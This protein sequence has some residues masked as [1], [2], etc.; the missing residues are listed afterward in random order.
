MGIAGEDGTDRDA[1]TDSHHDGGSWC[2]FRVTMGR[3]D[4]LELDLD[5]MLDVSLGEG[6]E[7]TGEF[8]WQHALCVT[9][10]NPD[11]RTEVYAKQVGDGR[12][13]FLRVWNTGHDSSRSIIHVR[14]L[15]V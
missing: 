11:V 13:P 15:A 10:S 7:P 6:V 14:N 12:T 8:N 5:E 2:A 9:S 1:S 4:S 3:A